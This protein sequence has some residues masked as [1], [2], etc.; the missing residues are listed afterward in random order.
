[1]VLLEKITLGKIELKNKIA[2]SAMT[3][4]RANADGA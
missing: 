2:M 4:S 1:M 3:R